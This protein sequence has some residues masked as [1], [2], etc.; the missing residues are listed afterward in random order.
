MSQSVFCE[1]LF[2]HGTETAIS[3]KLAD[4]V[5]GSCTTC[6][7]ALQQSNLIK[8]KHKCKMVDE[9][10]RYQ[11]EKMSSADYETSSGIVL[12]ACTTQNKTT[13]S[14]NAHDIPCRSVKA[15]NVQQADCSNYI[16]TVSE[17]TS[18]W[19]SMRYLAITI[20]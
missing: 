14:K 11:L 3:H 19:S 20:R 15:D 13:R 8:H 5:S 1:P 2:P 16:V 4:A 18:Y 12:D 9:I 10:V 6:S 7:S 17:Q